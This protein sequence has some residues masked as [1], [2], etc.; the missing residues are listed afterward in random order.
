MTDIPLKTNILPAGDGCNRRVMKIRLDKY[1]SDM[2]IGT[3]S[4]VKE[5]IKKGRIAVNNLVIKAS[6]L[7]I[8]T[9]SDTVCVDGNPVGYVEY[10]YYMLYKPAGVITAT[11][12]KMARTVTD[13][14]E[15]K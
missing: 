7:K 11:T 4:Q 10:E 5:Y 8:D 1:L 14:I 9:D 6:D 12:D 3:R 13:L 15:S 2:Q